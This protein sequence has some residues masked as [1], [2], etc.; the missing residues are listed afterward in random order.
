MYDVIVVGGG[1][2]G[3]STAYNCAKRGLKTILIDQRIKPGTP[4][5]CAEGINEEILEELDLEMKPEWVSQKIDS[6]ILS[7]FKHT[8]L[9]KGRRT[10]G[11]VL[12]RKIFDY[13]L[14]KRAE[15]A[16]AEL[17][18]GIKVK[19][20]SKNEVIL[21]DES[22]VEGKIIV[23][24]DG[25]LSIV[26]RASG[27]GN[28]KSGQG[29]QYEI[30]TSKT[31]HPN[32]LHC[33]LD[34]ELENEGYLWIF[35]KKNTLNVG[36]GSMKIHNMKPALREFVN[37]LDLNDEPLEETNA[38]LIPLH[39]PVKKFY[40]KNVLLVGDAAGH[41]N[42]LSGGGIPVAI[43]DGI[44]AAEV[45]EKHLKSNYP[46]SN[47]QKL[48]W[49]SD[50]GKATKASL[51]VKK[52]YLKL[53]KADQFSALLGNIGNQEITSVKQLMKVGT[54]IP[55]VMNKVKLLFLFKRFMKHLKYAW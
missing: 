24:A 46:L 6:F 5:Q 27:L 21:S 37:K 32:A 54:K 3:S 23:G 51:S 13:D 47:Y 34:P 31:A 10:R 35:P 11:F 50:F 38:G 15:N 22:V 52:S 43:Y 48:W 42:P 8:V 33:Y 39:G 20:L 2:G 16:G 30:Q 28:P 19:D 18:L 1:P 14:V 29:I 45:I 9:L 55:G 40:G 12:D 36:M 41:T 25:P 17:K 4:K 53:L 49:K 7:D 44:L 26:G